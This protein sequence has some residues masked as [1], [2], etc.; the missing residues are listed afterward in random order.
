M[1]FG[2]LDHEICAE[3]SLESMKGPADTDDKTFWVDSE[4]AQHHRASEVLWKCNAMPHLWALCF[5]EVRGL[6]V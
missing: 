5:I 3:E 2:T 4:R 6:E 1:A